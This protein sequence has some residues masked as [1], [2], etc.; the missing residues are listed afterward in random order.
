LTVREEDSPAAHK[1]LALARHL[2]SVHPKIGAAQI[3]VVR[4][5]YAPFKPGWNVSATFGGDCYVWIDAAGHKGL[6]RDDRPVGV[7][8]AEIH[9]RPP[10]PEFLNSSASGTFIRAL[11]A[12][13]DPLRDGEDKEKLFA[14]Y[15]QVLHSARLSFEACDKWA[16]ETTDFLDES[17]LERLKNPPLSVQDMHAPITEVVQAYLRFSI[18]G[19]VA[20][21]AISGYFAIL[22]DRYPAR[23]VDRGSRIERVLALYFHLREWVGKLM[24]ERANCSLHSYYELTQF[25][26]MLADAA[27]MIGKSLLNMPPAISR[28]PEA[29]RTRVFRNQRKLEE[30]KAHEL[31]PTFQYAAL[32]CNPSISD[33]ILRQTR[34]VVAPGGYVY[35][36]LEGMDISAS[37]PEAVFEALLKK[38]AGLP[39]FDLS[40]SIAGNE[41]FLDQVNRKKL[42]EALVHISISVEKGP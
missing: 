8:N 24:V 5:E 28:L 13:T 10:E 19:M 3:G 36:Q 27:L 38:T 25:A 17:L 23:S 30:T 7:S 31:L 9:R 2:M 29:Q 32:F 6:T 40:G 33:L 39:D 18:P 16:D 11:T 4:G 37:D 41:A 42:M 22:L 12:A 14:I 34:G 20:S 35:P 26:I 1:F 21:R 15:H